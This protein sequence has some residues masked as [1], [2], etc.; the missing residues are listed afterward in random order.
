MH[1]EIIEEVKNLW[2]APSL[3]LSL[4]EGKK[5]LISGANGM[6]PSSIVETLLVLND[7]HFKKPCSIMCLVRNEENFK[8]RF[9]K[10]HDRSDI[11]LIVSDVADFKTFDG[12]LDY[13]IHAA[14]Q[15][16]PKYYGTDTVGTIEAN[17]TGTKNLLEHAK[18]KNVESFLFFSS[19]EVY[20]SMPEGLVQITEKDYGLV[21]PMLLRSCY[22]ESK[23][24]GE[25]LCV[26]YSHQY[27]VPVKIARP[28]HTY[29]PG[30]R[31]D[32]GRIFADLVASVVKK[33]NIVLKSKGE[34]TRCFCYTAD[35]T[36]G[37]LR[38]LLHGNNAEAYNIGNPNQE[39]K[40]IELAQLMVELSNN[41]IK[42]IF[43]FEDSKNYVKSKVQ[44][45]TPE[46]SKLM[47]LGWQPK[48]DAK[49]GFL[50]TI[51]SYSEY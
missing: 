36:D 43:D 10:A 42:I 31:L 4:L 33:Q 44:R 35:A 40:I 7:N 3:D 30:M 12:E 22:A 15:A 51:R 49:E 17:V 26:S 48:I 25:T 21:D 19:S 24:L 37:F 45:N 16:S 20:G 39:L 5:I 50:R 23:R 34:A 46:I 6:L 28:F 27:G 8:K 9:P 11:K 29:G 1:H 14:S 47:N 13:I 38:I 32:D 41:E 2:N 18:E